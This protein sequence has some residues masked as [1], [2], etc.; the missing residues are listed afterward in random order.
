M[1]KK[2]LGNSEE[3]CENDME[4]MEE[5]SDKYEQVEMWNDVEN[6]RER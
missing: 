6:I 3:N 5:N 1:H 4:N 2:D